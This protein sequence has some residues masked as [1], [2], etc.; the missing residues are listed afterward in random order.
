MRHHLNL[1]QDAVHGITAANDFTEFAVDIVQLLG[2]RE[3][4]VHQPLFQTMNFL[5]RQR[6]VERNSNALCDLAQQLKIGGGKGLF[7]ALRQL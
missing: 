1:L 3:V 6:V 2:Q 5:V 7:F 4:F